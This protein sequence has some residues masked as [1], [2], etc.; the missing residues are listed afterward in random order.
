METK[1]CKNCKVDYPLSNYRYNTYNVC[2]GCANERDKV[3]KKNARIKTMQTLVICEMCNNTKQKKQFAKLK[4]FY[5]KHICTDCYPAFVAKQKNDWCKKETLSNPN[6]RIKK[7][8]AARLRSVLTKTDTT[9]NYIGCNIQ[10]L[11]EWL[12]F[13]FAEGMNWENYGIYWSIDHVIPVH[14]FDLTNE[15]EKLICWNWSNLFPETVHFNS[16]KKAIIN[17][18]QVEHVI[19]QLE[20]FKEEG[21]TTKWFSGKFMLTAP[22]FS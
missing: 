22:S 9:M 15:T 3:L 10:Y 13:N 6:Y 18:L 19:Q 1:C 20:K 8:I 16:T 17:N 5:K 4:K 21:S 11:R 12:E 2:K 14:K 7:S